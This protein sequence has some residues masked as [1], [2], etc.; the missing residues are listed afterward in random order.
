MSSAAVT[1]AGKNCAGATAYRL[2][3]KAIT[4]WQDWLKWAREYVASLNP[5]ALGEAGSTPPYPEPIKIDHV[6]G[7][8]L[9]YDDPAEAMRALRE[10]RW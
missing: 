6:D 10:R 9:D 7:I 8:F 4:S 3:H 5:I 2:R 1:V